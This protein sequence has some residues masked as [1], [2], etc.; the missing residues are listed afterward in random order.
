[1]ADQVLFSADLDNIEARRIRA[2]AFIAD[3]V[4]DGVRDPNKTRRA[5]YVLAVHNVPELIAALR[6]AYDR[7]R[8]LETQHDSGE[9]QYGFVRDDGDFVHHGDEGQARALAAMVKRQVYRR[10]ATYGP[11]VPVQETET[12]Q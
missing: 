7:I 12:G 4:A 8:D 5:A 3:E 6:A 9:W 1:M 2:L 10:H 11:V